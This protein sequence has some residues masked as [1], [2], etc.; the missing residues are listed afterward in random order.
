MPHCRKCGTRL[1]RIHRTLVE[2]LSYM[3]VFECPECNDVHRVARQITYYRGPQARC[4]HCGTFRL[5]ALASRDHIDRMLKTPMSL[6][7]KMMGGRL[8]HCRYC[9][10]QFYDRRG[11][12]QESA[13][14]TTMAG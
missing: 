7:Q 10:L 5:R 12:A 13:A 8:Y 2:R 1:R 4:P 14:K 6:L 3:G 9:R 11:L